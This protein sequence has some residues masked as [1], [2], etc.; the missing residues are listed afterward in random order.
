M[1]QTIPN[2]V[3]MSQFSV[4]ASQLLI[5]EKSL[6]EIAVMLG[7]DV[8]YAYDSA[9][10]NQKIQQF[11]QNMP[12]R[13]KLHYAIKANPYPPLVG[14]MVGW[15]D[16]FDVASHRE[17]LVALQSGMPAS[18]ISFAGPAKQLPELAAAIVAGVTLN[19][20]SMTELAR[21]IDL[22]KELRQLPKVSFRV[23][24][25]F[26]LKASGMKMGGGPKQF[27][28][29][30]EVLLETLGTL[31]YDTFDLVGFHIFWGSQNLSQ[32]AI[33]HAHA[34][35]FGLASK[36]VAVTPVRVKSINIGGGLGIPYFMGEKRLDLQPIGENLQHLIGHYQELKDVELVIEL[37]RFLVGEAGIYASRITDI[38]E[39]RG[40]TFL[41]TNGG[42]HHHLSNSG[43]FGQVIRKNYPVALGNKMDYPLMEQQVSA[44]GPLCTPLDVLAD[45][46]WLPKA[47]IG[48]WLVVFQSGAYGPTASPQDFLSHP[49]VKEILL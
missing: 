2:H 8:F 28:I 29:D 32:E 24:P 13:I 35:T 6:D 14:R 18:E 40:H 16:G 47:E 3:P 10:I 1:S 19:I 45:K 43:N 49:R 38:K 5:G 23:N 30:E 21:V 36:L 34:N 17:M 12:D 20:E 42:L 26:E 11:R 41:M 25:A 15:V 39:S 4:R 33:C 27:G 9:V 7:K 22:G 31:D 48:D 46:M 37:G 44:V